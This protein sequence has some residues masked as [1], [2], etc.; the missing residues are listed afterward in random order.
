MDPV[1]AGLA[2][3]IRHVLDAN[4]IMNPDKWRIFYNQ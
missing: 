1:T 4:R 2:N 3:K